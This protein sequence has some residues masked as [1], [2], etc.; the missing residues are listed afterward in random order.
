MVIYHTFAFPDRV[1]KNMFISILKIEKDI[2]IEYNLATFGGICVG[3]FLFLSGYGMYVYYKDTINTKN[4]VQ[5]ILKLYM[6][7][8]VIVSIFIPI[9]VYMGKYKFHLKEF[10]LTITALKPNYNGEWWFITLYIMLILFYP[11][12]VIAINKY[13]KNL[14]ITISFLINITGFMLTKISNRLIYQG[15]VI[16]LL[17]I[18]LGGQFLFVLGIVV[19]KYGLFDKL[20]NQLNISRIKYFGLT[21]I[22]SIIIWGVIKIPI[23]DEVGKLV[24]TPIFIF[25]LANSIKEKSRLSWLGDHST[26]IWLVHSFFCYYLFQEL[27]FAPKYSILIIAWIGILSIG[28]SFLINLFILRGCNNVLRYKR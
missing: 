14:I 26:N 10:L 4:I 25:T 18:L 28:C 27:A 17:N 6:N 5:R 13:N 16:S 20:K 8:W 11:L 23:I 22:I 12:I 21:I 2:P 19:A 3:M 24:L 1:D 15:L 7:Y 9:G